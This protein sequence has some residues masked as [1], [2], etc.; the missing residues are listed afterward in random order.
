MG[1][2]KAFFHVFILCNNQTDVEKCYQMFVCLKKAERKE[3]SK[4]NNQRCINTV[5]IMDLIHQFIY[6]LW[7]GV[8]KFL[9][10]GIKRCIFFFPLHV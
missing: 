2:F 8:E 6:Y 7:L 1:G 3:E 4:E 5:R 9:N 10:C